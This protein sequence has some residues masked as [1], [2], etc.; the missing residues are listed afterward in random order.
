MVGT[1]PDVD[2][3]S[4]KDRSIFWVGVSAVVIDV[5][6]AKRKAVEGI[7]AIGVGMKIF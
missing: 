6:K 4:K 2:G 7:L 1:N 3:A 5:V